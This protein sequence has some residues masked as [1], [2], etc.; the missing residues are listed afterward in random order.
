MDDDT[1]HPTDGPEPDHAA[2]R[3]GGAGTDS[4]T[5]PDADP[6][7][8]ANLGPLGP[9]AGIGERTGGTDVHPAAGDV[10]GHDAFHEHD[11]L[12]PIDPQTSGPQLFYGLRYHTHI[13]KPHEVE[14]LHD[15]VGHRLW[16]PATATVTF[17]VAIPCGQV[18]LAHGA[19]APDAAG[20]ALTAALGSE[21]YGFLSNPFLEANSRT[22]SFR[23]AVSVGP[24]GTRPVRGGHDAGR[25]GSVR[26]GAAAGLQHADQGRCPDPEPVGAGRRS[27][28]MTAGPP[29]RRAMRVIG[30]TDCHTMIDVY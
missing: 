6:E 25:T 9:M 23:I 24:D 2:G 12:Q 13:V 30:S 17:T 20:F 21:T 15:Q 1:G 7:T 4:Y 28:R 19:A 16:E 5:E 10:D 11:A 27:R 14:T 8:L 22:V 29:R 3:V 26:P 18:L